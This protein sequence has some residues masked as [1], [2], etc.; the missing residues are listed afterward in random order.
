MIRMTDARLTG[1]TLVGTVKGQFTATP[2]N[3]DQGAYGRPEICPSP[4]PSSCP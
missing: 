1:D 2:L 3:D 4:D